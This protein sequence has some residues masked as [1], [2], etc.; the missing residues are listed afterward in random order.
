MRTDLRIA[1]TLSRGSERREWWR[2][3]LTLVAALLATGFA[4]AAAGV[5]AV[6]GQVSIPFAHGLLDRPG[7]RAG[8]VFTLVLLLIPVLGLLAQ[9]ARLGAVHRHRRL[10]A[11]RL[12]GATPAQVRRI[13]AA[14]SAFPCLAGST[15]GLAAFAV[16]LATRGH[17]PRP[18]EWAVFVAIAL[19]VP[20]LA[21]AVGAF[22][23]RR[24]VSSPLDHVR[25]TTRTGGPGRCSSSCSWPPWPPSRRCSF[26]SRSGRRRRR[27]SCS[28]SA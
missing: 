5:A 19:S 22:A 20:V 3:S 21:T 8:V 10:A 1:W 27:S 18:V 15:S 24:V 7:E 17:D 25:R 2:F 11:M 9:C 28:S 23:L 14:E 26:C 6:A 16:L 13:A 4:L 12:A